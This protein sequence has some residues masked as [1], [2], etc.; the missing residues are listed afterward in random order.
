MVRNSLKFGT[1]IDEY[2]SEK[3][4]KFIEEGKK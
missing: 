1:P 3:V 4:K 2:V